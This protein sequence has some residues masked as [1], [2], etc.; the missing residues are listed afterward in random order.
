MIDYPSDHFLYPMA[1][2]GQAQLDS[3]K[4]INVHVYGYVCQP[5]KRWE[6]K[7]LWKA[8]VCAGSSKDLI[9]CSASLPASLQT[10]ER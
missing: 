5:K 4:T 7:L 6:T 2:F 1:I 10:L 3:L 9:E 8:L